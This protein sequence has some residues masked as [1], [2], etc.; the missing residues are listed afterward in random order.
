MSLV[1]TRRL[2]TLNH[3]LKDILRDSAQSVAIVTSHMCSEHKAGPHSEFHGATLSSFSSIALD[4]HPLVA[5]SL[6]MPSR[7]ATSL[8]NADYSKP[9]HMV[10]NLLS[11]C[12]ASTAVRFANARLHPHPFTETRYSL[13]EDG[14]P[15]LHDSLGAISCKL[16]L[17]PKPLHDLDAFDLGGSRPK[18]KEWTG[19]G[20]ASELFIARVV[21]VE[22]VPTDDVNNPLRTLPLVY[23]RQ[24]YGT[25][26]PLGP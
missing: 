24:G 2:S 18:E 21:R 11:A 6:R 5:F 12:Q 16:V 1:W 15:I 20:V 7:M 13:T 23:H 3:A 10:I 19:P 25:V 4:P 26:S 9:S 17:P 8:Q 22:K 14:L